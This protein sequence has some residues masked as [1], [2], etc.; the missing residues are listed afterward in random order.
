MPDMV[1]TWN[2]LIANFVIP[3]CLLIL[4][5]AI[6]RQFSERD[7]KDDRISALIAEKE[8]EKERHLAEVD[9]IKQ[10]DISMWRKN[11]SETQCAIKVA[12]D[13]VEASLHEKVPWDHCNERR[14]EEDQTMKEI[15]I[16]LRMGGI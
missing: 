13:R 3:L 10:K 2:V 8:V 16:R 4:W 1:W 11:F 12:L 7:K 6:K 5:G 9:A 14:R 15:E